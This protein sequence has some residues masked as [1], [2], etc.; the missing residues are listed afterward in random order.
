MNFLHK[1][2]DHKEIRFVLD[3]IYRAVQEEADAQSAL[4]WIERRV[5]NAGPP[6]QPCG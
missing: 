6:T 2:F 5:G 4:D 1:P 3:R